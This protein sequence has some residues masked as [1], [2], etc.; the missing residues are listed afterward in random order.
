MPIIEPHVH[1]W[2]LDTERYPWSPA[3]TSPPAES[4]TAEELLS[5]LAA[6]E[7]A[8]AVLVQ[9]IY[10]G[11]D[12][13]YL[14]DVLARYPRQFAGVCLVDPLD[15][16]APEHLAR[17]AARGFTGLRLRPSHD[18]ASTWL[19]DPSTFP[20]WEKAG[21]LGFTVSLLL[22]I[23]QLRQL[24]LPLRHFPG[25]PV[26]IDHMAWPP[27]EEGPDGPALRNLL[28]LVDYPQVHVKITD[29]WAISPDE[30][31]PFRK[32]E[33]IFR[34]VFREFGRERCLWGSDWPLVTRHC[35]YRQVLDLYRG[36][37]EW[38]T[39]E[40]QEWLLYR[41]VQRLYPRPFASLTE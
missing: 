10:Y 23:E 28:R 16:R 37:W 15:P 20:L 25:V 22:H 34:R 6:N 24:D 39:P 29:P 17:E 9:V 30:P 40:D 14:A 27:L 21:E 26:I 13:S 32:A 18:R 8:G 31:Y 41:T 19:G 35:S 33:P 2:S 12:N 11:T 3:T 7:V 5:V 38:I 4:A 1:V 36:V